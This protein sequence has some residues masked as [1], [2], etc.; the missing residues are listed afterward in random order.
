[1]QHDNVKNNINF[2]LS[3]LSAASTVLYLP[4][5]SFVSNIALAVYTHVNVFVLTATIPSN[6]NVFMR[7]GDTGLWCASFLHL[8]FY[9]YFHFYCSTFTPCLSFANSLCFFNLSP[10]FAL[11]NSINILIILLHKSK[12]QFNLPLKPKKKCIFCIII[13]L[14]NATSLRSTSGLVVE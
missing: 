7:V 5:F 1:M 4:L 11:L 3:L 9:F 2:I 10:S 6:S 14:L 8:C 12:N 13:Q